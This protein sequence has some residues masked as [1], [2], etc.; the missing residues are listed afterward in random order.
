MTIE[1]KKYNEDLKKYL[2]S[3]IIDEK[4]NSFD[5]LFRMAKGAFPTTVYSFLSDDKIR[6]SLSEKFYGLKEVNEIIPESNPVNFD[7]RFDKA[8]VNRFIRL[9]RR[10]KYR[11]VVLFGTPS[12]LVPC[13][14]V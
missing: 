12:L 10:K 7:W 4:P 14:S 13:Q 1:E 3:I 2:K 8:T 6:E 9:V 5:D 11:K